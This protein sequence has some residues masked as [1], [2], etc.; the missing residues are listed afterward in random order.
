VK[1]VV[2]ASP[3]TDAAESRLCLLQRKAIPHGNADRL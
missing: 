1:D 2:Y 3:R